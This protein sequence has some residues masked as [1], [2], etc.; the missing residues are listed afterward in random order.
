[1]GDVLF[2]LKAKIHVFLFFSN[3]VASMEFVEWIN[4]IFLMLFLAFEEIVQQ[5]N[6]INTDFERTIIFTNNQE[7]KH[8]KEL[9]MKEKCIQE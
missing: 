6:K 5:V 3:G 8:S 2:A 4:F 1:M 7:K 9:K